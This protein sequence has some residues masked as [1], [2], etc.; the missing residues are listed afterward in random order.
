MRLL[1]CRL[2]LSASQQYLEKLWSIVSIMVNFV[3]IMCHFINFAIHTGRNHWIETSDSSL[4]LSTNDDHLRYSC[5]RGAST[6]RLSCK[7]M[8]EDDIWAS[9]C[10][11][12]VFR[13]CNGFVRFAT[14][15]RIMGNEDDISPRDHIYSPGIF[16]MRIRFYILQFKNKPSM[17]LRLYMGSSEL[18]ISDLRMRFQSSITKFCLSIYQVFQSGFLYSWLKLWMLFL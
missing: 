18:I 17:S 14:F 7:M 11:E 15:Q 16:A 2:L 3:K 9:P 12:F 1:M 8:P 6:S 13:K 4:Q 5:Q 10:N